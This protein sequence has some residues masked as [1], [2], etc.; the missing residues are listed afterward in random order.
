[1]TITYIYGTS[2]YVNITNRCTNSCEFCVRTT[3]DGFYS[4]D[5]L[6]LER[7]PTRAEILE[8]ILARSL[9]DFGELVFCGYGEPTMRLSDMLWVA[10]R[11]KAVSEI[12]VRLN[13]NGHCNLI[14]GDDMSPLFEGAVDVISISLNTADAVSYDRICHSVYGE[15][16]YGA[17]IDFAARVKEFVPKT[18]LSVVRG[19]ISEDDIDVCKKTAEDAGV[20]LRVR[21]L[22]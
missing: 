1:M 19:T 4:D 12:P 9:S 10:R 14:Y 8:D 3:S 6:W 21:E 13:T 11:V 20:G 5:P 7:E 15:D 22:V 16:A 2:L 17:V 18:I